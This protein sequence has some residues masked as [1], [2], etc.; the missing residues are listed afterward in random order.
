M[1]ALEGRQWRLRPDQDHRSHPT[2]SAVRQY[3]WIEVRQTSYRKLT[4]FSL[5][6]KCEIFIGIFQTGHLYVSVIVP[7]TWCDVLWGKSYTYIRHK[8]NIMTPGYLRTM[9]PPSA[10][11]LSRKKPHRRCDAHE[12]RCND[13]GRKSA[14]LWAGREQRAGTERRQ[15]ADWRFA[16]IRRLN[17]EHRPSHNKTV[18]NPWGSALPSPLGLSRNK[19]GLH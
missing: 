1:F 9:A 19:S 3:L 8:K 5:A 6:R 13:E 18:L 2:A 14:V 12:R 17:R 16:L 15:D 4:Y 10:S 7:A 11:T